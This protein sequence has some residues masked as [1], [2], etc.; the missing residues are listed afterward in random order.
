MPA[1]CDDYKDMDLWKAAFAVA[2]ATNSALGGCDHPLAA[3]TLA[4][5]S[6]IPTTLALL[7]V[8]PDTEIEIQVIRT[9]E[10]LVRLE[11]QLVM[12]GVTKPAAKIDVLKTRLVAIIEEEGDE[13]D[14]DEDSD[15][16]YDEDDA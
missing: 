4:T 13:E 10:Q 11:H 3:A 14:Y 8:L 6:E 12:T 16:Y 15:V 9:L 2:D 1:L 7:S 5:A